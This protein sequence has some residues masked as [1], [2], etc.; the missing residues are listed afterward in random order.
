VPTGEICTFIAIT[1]RASF[2]MV[3]KTVV[4]GAAVLVAISAPTLLAINTARDAR[5]TLVGFARGDNFTI[6]TDEAER[7]SP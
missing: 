4:A 5:L 7:L 2:E 1:S 6:Y 3:Q